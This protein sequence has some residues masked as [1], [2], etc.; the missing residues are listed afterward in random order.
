MIKVKINVVLRENILDPQGKAINNALNQLGY[1]GINNVRMGKYIELTM[2]QT[3]NQ[4]EQIKAICE[5]LLAN[6]VIENYTYT[7]ENV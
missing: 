5:Q 1:E 7:I 2:P 3:D 4:D 6:T